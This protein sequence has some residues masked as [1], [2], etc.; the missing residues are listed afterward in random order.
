MKK[1]SFWEDLIGIELTTTRGLSA[2]VTDEHGCYT[3]KIYH[4]NEIEPIIEI[5]WAF[6]LERMVNAMYALGFDLEYKAPFDLFEFL[7]EI[8]CKKTFK[9][10]ESNYHFMMYADDDAIPLIQ[11]SEDQIVGALYLG[12]KVEDPITT[13]EKKFREEGVTKFQLIEALEELMWI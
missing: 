11:E 6:D 8:F 7:R 2:R 13:V 12:A 10:D 5:D 4:G 9:F 1:I 3:A